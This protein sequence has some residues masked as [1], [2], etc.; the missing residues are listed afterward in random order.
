[1]SITH[2]LT[3]QCV[4]LSEKYSVMSS[5]QWIYITHRLTVSWVVF[6]EHYTLCHFY[7]SVNNN[8]NVMSCTQLA[9]LTVPWVVQCTQWA[10]ILTVP[11][12]II[13][14]HYL[15]RTL[16]STH[17]ELLT[18]PWVVFNEHFSLCHFSTQWTTITMSWVVLS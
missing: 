4:V 5:T 14:E 16:S 9:I 15:Y 6:N 3:V 1:M 13:S 7:Y 10:I 12:V 18:V 8:H 2:W 17:W 11:W